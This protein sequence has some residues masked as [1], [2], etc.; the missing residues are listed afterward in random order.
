M[1][2][3]YNFS[4]SESDM[5]LN[6]FLP[7]FDQNCFPMFLLVYDLLVL[8]TMKIILAD[9]HKLTRICWLRLKQP[10]KWGRLV[11]Q[12]TDRCMHG[13]IEGN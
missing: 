12:N 9:S 8:I 11:H 10:S 13:D 5:L 4:I 6:R 3:D 7:A 2:I 1:I